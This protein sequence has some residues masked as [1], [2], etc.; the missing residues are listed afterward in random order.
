M[1]QSVMISV[2]AV[3]VED[4]PV[5]VKF[6]LHSMKATEATEVQYISKPSKMLD[7]NIIFLE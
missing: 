1:R 3:K 6:I 2:S 4:L 7:L 5:I